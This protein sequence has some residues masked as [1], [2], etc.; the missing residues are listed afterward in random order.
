MSDADGPPD[1]LAEIAGLATAIA[2]R[3]L[4]QHAA[5]TSIPP[6]QFTML[7]NAARMLQDNG[8]PWPP[9]VESVL[10]EVA[11][12]AYEVDTAP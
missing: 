8:V 10:M 4:E 12:R 11:R 5:G 9:S 6:V 2:D 3:I 7:V 1:R